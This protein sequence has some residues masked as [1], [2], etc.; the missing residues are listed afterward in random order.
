LSANLKTT[1]AV[2]GKYIQ[3]LEST[4]ASLPKQTP[5]STTTTV[6]K[7]KKKTVVIV[8]A[9][10]T[11]HPATTTTHP[12]TTTTH[13]ATT[14]TAKSNAKGAHVADPLGPTTVP[15]TVPIAPTT[16][17]PS[18]SSAGTGA[19]T[20]P[21]QTPSSAGTGSTATTTQTSIN[22]LS[23]AEEK[24]TLGGELAH[25][26]AQ[27]QQ[28]L[29]SGV[30]GSG[31]KVVSAA[32]PSTAVKLNSSPSPLSNAWVRLLLGLLCGLLLA[33]IVTWLLDAYDR[34]LRTSE[35]AEEVFGLP[36]IV[37]I[38][39]PALA[40]R[41]VIPIIDV[42]ADPFSPAAEAYRYLHVAI[43]SAPTVTWVRRGSNGQNDHW[44]MPPQELIPAEAGSVRSGGPGSMG[45]PADPAAASTPTGQ[46]GTLMPTGIPDVAAAK[47]RRFSILITS[48][49]DEATRSLAVVNLAA[50]FAEAG[51]RVLVATTGGMRTHFEGESAWLSA[52]ENL[53]P[54]GIVSNARPSQI[55]GVSSLAL[56]QVLSNPSQLTQKADSLIMAAREVVDVMLIEA[57]LLSTQD[58]AAVLHSVDLV[59]VV[60]E[61]WD[62]T[63][64]EAIGSQ[65]LLAQRRPPVLGLVM[66]NMRSDVPTLHSA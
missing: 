13:P 55:P 3:N 14:T 29:A 19:T 12:E 34:R 10:T 9:T 24:R 39:P 42:I 33:V 5:P 8:P 37:E 62:T 61:A 6:P 65:R 31:F 48:P 28:L 46:T 1:L 59:V 66:T 35:R 11:T 50:V 7:V 49:S 53:D 41:S 23:L 27:Q 51:D 64:K 20:I 60:C 32:D 36:V 30:P 18:T 21:G 15:T 17:A 45:A 4:I 56:G 58:A 22:N 16:I 25:A 44:E 52:S 40:T 63:V 38:P 43:M 47:H 57:P 54:S 2:Q 26:L